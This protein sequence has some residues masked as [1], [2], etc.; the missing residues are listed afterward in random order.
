MSSTPEEG[1]DGATEDAI[2]LPDEAPEAG[3]LTNGSEADDKQGSDLADIID[4]TEEAAVAD[5]IERNNS[6]EGQ[7]AESLVNED[8]TASQRR[9]I[10]DDLRSDEETISVP[11]DSPSTQVW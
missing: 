5:R 11:D 10:R 1:E 4:D 2:A 3:G 8:G 7:D 6:G 9:N